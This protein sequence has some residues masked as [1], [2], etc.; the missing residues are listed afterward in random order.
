MYRKAIELDSKNARAWAGLAGCLRQQ[1][2]YGFLDPV[3]GSREAKAALRRSFELDDELPEAYEVSSVLELYQFGFH[4][5]LAAIRKAHSL[6][7]NNARI[8]SWYAITEA[9][10]GHFDA[11]MQR[12]RQAVELDPLDAT[13]HL[14]LGRVGLWARRY[15]EAEKSLRRA[16]ELSPGLTSGSVFLSS[17]ILL[18]GRVQEAFD[19]L[20]PNEAP[21][22]RLCGQTMA[23]HSLGRK[24]DSDRAM[25]ELLTQG[26]EWATQIA[27]S[28]AWCGEIDQAF[29][30]LE[31][32]YAA[33]DPGI[34]VTKV[35]P[36]L[37][38]L[39][40]DARWPVLLKKIGFP[41]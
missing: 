26:D 2:G 35:H 31:R 3:Q 38:N 19:I 40:G 4:E 27:V 13:F 21:G 24:E 5:A 25:A 22:F 8:L 32:G 23:L 14:N 9:I 17:A 33:R 29:Q 6:A 39:H 10:W 15:V 20:D 18:Q 11:A 36:M 28:Y 30:W 1:S 12:G 16:L 7:P 37:A 34:A 41:D